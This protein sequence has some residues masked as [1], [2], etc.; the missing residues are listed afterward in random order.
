MNPAM[1]VLYW[2]PL[3][4]IALVAI[5]P[6]AAF[7]VPVVIGPGPAPSGRL[8][9]SNY[10]IVAGTEVISHELFVSNGGASH[11]GGDGLWAH[12]ATIEFEGGLIQGADV[13]TVD[14]VRSAIGGAAYSTG[15]PAISTLNFYDGVYRGGSVFIDAPVPPDASF[16]GGAALAISGYQNIIDVKIYGGL[17]EGG[18]VA[19]ASA[20]ET[21]LSRAPSLALAGGYGG[22]LDIHGGTFVGAIRLKS[23]MRYTI[24]GSAFDI[25]PPPVNN[26]V[27]EPANFTVS[28]KYA[29]GTPFSLNFQASGGYD[30]GNGK[31]KVAEDSNALTFYARENLVPEPTA[32][33]LAVIV[34]GSIARRRRGAPC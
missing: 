12:S 17:F 30:F 27:V 21:I 2:L 19:T 24:H 22:T 18:V 10:R 20:P 11:H 25:Q 28:G 3:L 5:Q 31:L 8:L 6:Q 9:G 23:P 29:D 4:L 33:S 16:H 7:S 34:C 13:T 32:W 14:G 26:F 1:K 15:N